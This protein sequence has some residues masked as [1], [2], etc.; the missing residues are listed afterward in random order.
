[1]ALV[2][3]GTLCFK[4]GSH[5][6]G[7]CHAS[8]VV[9]SP[10]KRKKTTDS[11]T[12]KRVTHD[13]KSKTGKKKDK[14]DHQ[15]VLEFL[16][17]LVAH[18]G[19]VTGANLI[20]DRDRNDIPPQFFACHKIKN[21]HVIIFSITHIQHMIT[22]M[23][24]VNLM[25][26]T[27][28]LTR[29][30]S[31]QRNS[32]QLK[33][34]DGDMFVPLLFFGHPMKTLSNG[35]FVVVRM[36]VINP[37]IKSRYDSNRCTHL[38]PGYRASFLR[39]N[40][41]YNMCNLKNRMK[42]WNI[43]RGEDT[44]I[45]KALF[46]I[47][48]L[49]AVQTYVMSPSFIKFTKDILGQFGFINGIPKPQAGYWMMYGHNQY[50]TWSELIKMRAA[51]EITDVNKKELFLLHFGNVPKINRREQNTLLKRREQ[52]M[53]EKQRKQ[54]RQDVLNGLYRQE[55][56]DIESEPSS[57]DDDDEI[58]FLTDNE[59]TSQDVQIDE[60]KWEDMKKPVLAYQTSENSETSENSGPQV[61]ILE[62]TKVIPNPVIES[63]IVNLDTTN[64]DE[65]NDLFTDARLDQAL[66]PQV[67]SPTIQ[68]V[69]I[70]MFG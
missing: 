54:T 69:D 68:P 47:P 44:E 50:P 40:F 58:T 21:E 41:R 59:L 45:A 19:P 25:S 56:L 20:K 16:S 42:T 4:I 7:C 67:I 28:M 12:S 24:K 5:L 34:T 31:T 35:D 37:M 11:P 55:K 70:S 3:D 6:P 36:S 52:Q 38:T 23:K 32:W 1:M 8:K 53:K 18:Y 29:I 9:D 49:P 10:K 15:I 65:F 64:W 26:D 13:L 60:S 2:D 46:R 14:P 66:S 62:H 63:P 51:T 39:K 33:L 57:S 48:C 43:H 30:K 22:A 17:D 27:G 61:V